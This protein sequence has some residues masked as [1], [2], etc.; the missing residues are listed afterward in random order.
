MA[1]SDRISNLSLQW[2]AATVFP[3]PVFGWVGS[4]ATPITNAIFSCDSQM[5]Y[6]GFYDGSVGV[7]DT[8]TLGL[9]YRISQTAYLPQ[10]IR[11]PHN[12]FHFVFLLQESHE[13]RNIREKEE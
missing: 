4:N 11:Y 9:C 13:P 5:I 2:S 3:E 6:A 1:F 10:P 7:F 12:I 8:L